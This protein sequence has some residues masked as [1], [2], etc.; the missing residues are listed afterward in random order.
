MTESGEAPAYLERAMCKKCENLRRE[1]VATRT[2]SAELTD[3]ASIVI[4]KADLKALEERLI[5]VI[6]EHYASER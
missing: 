6:G 1:I 3:P 2:L 5:R 4:N